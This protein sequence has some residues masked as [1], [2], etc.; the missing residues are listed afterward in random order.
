[1]EL[2]DQTAAEMLVRRRILEW[3]DECLFDAKISLTRVA[4]DLAPL[5][6]E[7]LENASMV[8]I[9]GK[10]TSFCATRVD[11]IVAARLKPELTR[12]EKMASEKLL[13]ISNAATYF[14]QADFASKA[15]GSL[16]SN[17]IDIGSVGAPVALGAGALLAAPAMA[18]G[19]TAAFFGLVTTSA[20]SVPVLLGVFGVASIATATGLTRGFRLKERAVNRLND[21][22][23][24]SIA[25]SIIGEPTTEGPQSALSCYRRSI[26]TTTSN[27]IQELQYDSAAVV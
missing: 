2:S 8:E 7:T 27:I 22:V 16:W 13:D 21:K 5:I 3:R 15:D 25:A 10:P 14:E 11:P 26:E 1:M 24:T 9:I 18:V 19:T 12:L 23:L 20:I 6:R 4:L 17:A